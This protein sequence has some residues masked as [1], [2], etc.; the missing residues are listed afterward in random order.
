[1]PWCGDSNGI[2][3][4]VLWDQQVDSYARRAG[5]SDQLVSCVPKR[6]LF[7]LVSFMSWLHNN[8]EKLSIKQYE[9]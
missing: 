5:G 6:N 2:H 8:N 1:M 3:D 9:P 7:V 4:V